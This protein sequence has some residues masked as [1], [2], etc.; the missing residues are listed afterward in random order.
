MLLWKVFLFLP[1]PAPRCFHDTWNC[2]IHLGATEE[3]PE[4][5]KEV[6]LHRAIELTTSGATLSGDF[7][8]HK[9]V[10]PLFFQPLL[11]RLFIAMAKSALSHAPRC[12]GNKEGVNLLFPQLLSSPFS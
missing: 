4:N 1:F 8:L 11:H 9:S 6:K 12:E 7:L 10:S 3:S 2:C 5:C